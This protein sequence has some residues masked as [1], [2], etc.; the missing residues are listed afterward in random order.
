MHII[1][2]HVVDEKFVAVEALEGD[3]ND[4]ED[5]MLQNLTKFDLSDLPHLRRTLLT[6]RKSLFHEGNPV[7]NLSQGL[8]LY[9]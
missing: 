7:E 6:I 9:Q 8:S 3:L 5:K 1:L 2:D 4:A